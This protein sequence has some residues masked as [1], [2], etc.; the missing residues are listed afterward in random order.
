[1]ADKVLFHKL[2]GMKVIYWIGSILTVAA[3]AILSMILQA[4]WD[5]NRAMGALTQ[6]VANADETAN[7]LKEIMK[8]DRLRAVQVHELV[9]VHSAQIKMLTETA[10]EHDERID[11]LASK[12]MGI[13]KLED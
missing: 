2:W 7:E 6:S 1:M 13:R 10:K 9:L 12:I 5:N 3:T 11:V 4:A 8:E